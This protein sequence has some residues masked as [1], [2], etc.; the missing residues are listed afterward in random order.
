M[1]SLESAVISELER[2]GLFVE[3]DRGGLQL[4]G[5]PDGDPISIW[6]DETER[7]IRAESTICYPIDDFSPELCRAMD[8]VNRTRAGVG[9]S[10]REANRSLVA[11]TAWTSPNRDPAPNQLHLL[12]G[13]LVQMKERDAP[14]LMRVAEGDAGWE[15]LVDEGASATASGLSSIGEGPATKIIRGNDA[16]ERFREL[17]GIADGE[18]ELTSRG[19]TPAD[20]RPSAKWRRDSVASE[21]AHRGAGAGYEGGGPAFD[22]IP[23]RKLDAAPPSSD[24]STRRFD[25]PAAGEE[26]GEPKRLSRQALQ[27]AVSQTEN[28]E[29]KHYDYTASRRSLGRRLLKFFGVVGAIGLVFFIFASYYQNTLT[30]GAFQ[31][32]FGDFGDWFESATTDPAEEE[33]KRRDAM[34]AGLDLLILEL[35]DPLPDAA[36]HERHVARSLEALGDEARAKLQDLVARSASAEVRRGAFSLWR[37]EGYSRRPGARLA[38]LERLHAETPPAEGD[39][40]ARGLLSS[41]RE[42][43]PEDPELIEALG[44]AEGPTWRTFVKLLGR[45][46]DGAEARAEALTAWRPKVEGEE[47]LLVL[48]ALVR[49]EHGPAAGLR[50]LIAARGVEWLGGAGEALALRALESRPDAVAEALEVEDDEVRLALVE[51]LA[52]EGEAAA[53]PHLAEVVRG[54]P[55]RRVRMRT[56]RA[57]GNMRAPG[58]T[59]PLAVEL[60]REANAEDSQ[61]LDELLIAL[62]KIPGEQTAA[63]LREHLSAETPPKQRYFAVKTLE[64]LET[65]DAVL[66]LIQDGLDDADERLRRAALAALSRLQGVAT[67]KSTI[68]QGLSEF[69]RIARNDES[70]Q[71]R[72]MA[73]RIYKRITGHDP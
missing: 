61:L 42:Q 32:L 2:Q 31:G 63:E 69:R 7:V 37:A 48:E 38:L 29:L 17:M 22:E 44:W 45:P 54:D 52:D 33:A 6:V 70:E 62:R 30:G 50:Q 15:E 26:H 60:T 53:V 49:T 67:L 9:V 57:L 68:D 11:S 34:A 65:A 71:V 59:W 28:V 64:Q 56:V 35:D 73:G 25:E 41:L 66:V 24:A 18:G 10:Y 55:S 8:Y 3:H 58:A 1:K 4:S 39:P 46:G 72:A 51:L 27:I 21:V 19:G 16:T 23:T 20:E 13:L 43:P 5:L 47:A 36:A 40:V 14:G 12:V